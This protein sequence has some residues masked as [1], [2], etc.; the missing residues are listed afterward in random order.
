MQGSHISWTPLE[1]LQQWSHTLAPH[2]ELKP[3]IASEAERP[4]SPVSPDM[5]YVPPDVEVTNRKP[6][7]KRKKRSIFLVI[8]TVMYGPRALN[9]LC[10]EQNTFLG[11]ESS[12]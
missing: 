6:K 3:P 2:N 7:R 12:V 4:R 1:D 9:D 5:T 11:R 8:L 10:Q